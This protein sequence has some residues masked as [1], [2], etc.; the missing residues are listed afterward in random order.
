MLDTKVIVGEGVAKQHEMVVTKLVIWTK[1]RKKERPSKNKKWWKLKDEDCRCKLKEKVIKSGVLEG[2]SD[3]ETVANVMRST[4]RIEFGESVGKRR[5]ED[6]ETWWWN[7]E[8]QES[9]QAKK[10]AKKQWDIS[11]EETS[12]EEYKSAKK[13]G[14]QDVAKMMN[15]AYKELY[16]RLGT[17][18]EAGCCQSEE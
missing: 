10:E 3:W 14:K 8:M 17:K 5:L 1:W 13:R 12:K 2:Q 16:D 6:Q 9:I 4:A 7:K 11:R 15:K 18:G